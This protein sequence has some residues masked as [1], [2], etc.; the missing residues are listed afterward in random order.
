MCI[1]PCFINKISFST[2]FQAFFI[3]IMQYPDLT[4]I[5]KIEHSSKTATPSPF[6][7]R[8]STFLCLKISKENKEDLLSYATFHLEKLLLHKSFD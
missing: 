3:L 1:Y 7:G 5:Y 6:I 2:V 4:R 8:I